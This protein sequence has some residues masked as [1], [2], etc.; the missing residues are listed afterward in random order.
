MPTGYST[1]SS[2]PNPAAW[3]W[4][5][6]SAVR[7]WKP[8]MAG[9]RPRKPTPAPRFSSHEGFLLGIGRPP[10][11]FGDGV[12]VELGVVRLDIRFVVDLD[13]HIGEVEHKVTDRVQA[14]KATALPFHADVSID[15]AILADNLL[16]L[17]GGL[18]VCASDHDRRILAIVYGQRDHSVGFLIPPLIGISASVFSTSNKCGFL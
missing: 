2:P 5:S 17:E 6:R 9:C 13:H 16:T 15:Q 18:A 3:A 10:R 8:T 7:S 14:V 4:D 1:P 12:D 11:I